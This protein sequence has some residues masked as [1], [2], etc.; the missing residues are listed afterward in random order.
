MLKTNW[1][2]YYDAPARTAS[3]TRKITTGKI[4]KLISTYSAQDTNDL[5]ILELGGANSCFYEAIQNHL[6]PIK[7]TIIDN[8][9]TGLEKFK[10]NFPN[11]KNVNLINQDLLLE[12]KVNS[13][14]SVVYSVGLIEHFDEVGTGKIIKQHFEFVKPGGIVLITFPTP[15]WL[16]KISRLIIE[17]MGKWIFVDERPIKFEEV[18]KEISQYGKLLY[19]E[20]NWPIILT[21]GIVVIRK[22]LY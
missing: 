2:D 19:R 1:D 11:A 15:T 12:T 18:L 21:Q 10:K 14:F 17:S 4:L 8:N 16:Y 6:S 20:I 9:S 5:E 7:Y 3:I 13:Q 22:D